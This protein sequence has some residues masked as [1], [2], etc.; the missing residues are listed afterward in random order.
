VFERDLIFDLGLHEGHDARFYL[1]KGF[2]VVSL[3]ANPHFSEQARHGFEADAAA[4]RFRLVDKALWTEADSRLTFY[5]RDDSTGW[6]SVF[7]EV[8]ERD[9]QASR[10]IEVDTTTLG[11]LFNEHGV[12]YYAKCDLEGADKIFAEQ[13]GLERHHPAFVSVEFD[14]LEVPR[15]LRRA[16]YDCFQ[17]VNQAHLRL[18]RPPRPA[19]EGRFVDVTFHGKMSGLFGRELHPRYWVDFDR[20]TGQFE[21]WQRLPSINPIVHYALRHWGKF[22]N[23]GWLITKSWLDLHATT[24]EILL[25]APMC[26]LE[27][28][29]PGPGR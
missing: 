2:R 23:R 19:R 15:L 14:S 22:F 21:L 18:W 28:R 25:R 7:V 24:K 12:P 10:S 6:S 27:N 20:F 13:L 17:I 11:R 9:G 16:G 4:G 5:V 29:V 3:E 26:S 1:D 8:A